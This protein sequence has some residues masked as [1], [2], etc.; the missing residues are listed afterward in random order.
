MPRIGRTGRGR[1][2][3]IAELVEIAKKDSMNLNRWGYM[4]PQWFALSDEIRDFGIPNLQNYLTEQ[5][6]QPGTKVCVEAYYDR[7]LGYSVIEVTQRPV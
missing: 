1:Y 2:A 7:Y 3:S 5:I 4:A 6:N